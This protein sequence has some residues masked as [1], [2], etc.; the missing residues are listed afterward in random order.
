MAENKING[1][2]KQIM[3]GILIILVAGWIGY[4]SIRGITLQEVVAGIHTRVSV[5]EA[6]AK[7]I[8][9]DMIEIK[10]LIRQVRDDQLR[11]EKKER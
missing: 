10:T 3:G 7:T 8:K 1:T 6:V 2:F 9:E 5:L 4:I 11:R